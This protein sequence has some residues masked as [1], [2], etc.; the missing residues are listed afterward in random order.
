MNDYIFTRCLRH[1]EGVSRES[2]FFVDS[3]NQRQIEYHEH[4][5]CLALSCVLCCLDNKYDAIA[6][7]EKASSFVLRVISAMLPNLASQ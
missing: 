3:S 4:L 6:N 1:G 5:P 7:T 2:V